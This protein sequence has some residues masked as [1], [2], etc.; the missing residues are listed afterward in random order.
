MLSIFSGRS[1]QGRDHVA[2]ALACVAVIG[3]VPGVTT[4]GVE[5]NATAGSRRIGSI[6]GR[7]R[8]SASSGWRPAHASTS[9]SGNWTGS[10]SK[11]AR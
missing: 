7:S 10:F 9:A 6:E 1:V 8:R 3:V 11:Y 4:L 5:G 2:P